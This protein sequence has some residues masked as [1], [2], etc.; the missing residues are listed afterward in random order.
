[1][2][3]ASKAEPIAFV[4]DT[5]NNQAMSE[6]GNDPASV[7]Q[8]G[9]VYRITVLMLMALMIGVI[10][11]LAAIA[12]VELVVWLNTTLLISPRAR[13]QV[14]AA[15]WVV[16]LATVAVPTLGGACCWRDALKVVR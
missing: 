11:S 9:A 2:Q 6:R 15:P 16:P 12:F 3:S 13:V 10:V 5:R 14:E 1:M 4:G 8:G 7:E